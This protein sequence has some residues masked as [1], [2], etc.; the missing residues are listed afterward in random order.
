MKHNY[1]KALIVPFCFISNCWASSGFS[2]DM[3]IPSWYK[4][5][6]KAITYVEKAAYT[7]TALYGTQREVPLQMRAR[8]A[9]KS[10]LENKK[11]WPSAVIAFKEG[12][13]RVITEYN[14]VK[15]GVRKESLQTHEAMVKGFAAVKRDFGIK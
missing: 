2:V 5:N 14:E 12:E 15:R 3:Q 7:L 10:V 8:D 9:I 4:R 1:L 13:T 6:E 11:E